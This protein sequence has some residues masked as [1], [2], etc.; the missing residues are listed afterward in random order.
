[1][2]DDVQSL[3]TVNGENIVTG[4]IVLSNVEVDFNLE[5]GNLNIPEKLC[6]CWD[7]IRLMKTMTGL[8]HVVALGSNSLA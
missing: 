2:E 7:K 3:L 5:V 4:V 1:M 6:N 8:S